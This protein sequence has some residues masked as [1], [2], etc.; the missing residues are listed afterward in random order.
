MSRLTK[1]QKLGLEVG[2][3]KYIKGVSQ[4][5]DY[6]SVYLANIKLPRVVLLAC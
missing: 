4:V 2:L 1:K 5:F 6:V 3:K